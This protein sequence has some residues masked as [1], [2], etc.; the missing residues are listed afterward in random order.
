MLSSTKWLDMFH[1]QIWIDRET[2]YQLIL[3]QGLRFWTANR[4][5]RRWCILFRQ[6]NK[7]QRCSWKSP[8][9]LKVSIV[10]AR[11]RPWGKKLRCCASYRDAS[12]RRGHESIPISIC[13][14][15]IH[16]PIKT[17]GPSGTWFWSIDSFLL[18][19][20]YIL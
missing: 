13:V 11:V 12:W 15:F 1:V 20:E 3:T 6:T 16:L 17:V 9:L 4:S 10:T 8:C 14:V 5:K 19:K 18:F 2:S 7:V